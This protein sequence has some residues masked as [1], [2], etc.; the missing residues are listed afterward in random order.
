MNNATDH[1]LIVFVLSFFV[2][3]LSAMIGASFLR[4]QRKLE[5]DVRQDFGVI[6]AATLTLLGLIIGFSFSMAVSRYDQRKNYE[7]AEANAIGT[8]YVRADLLPAADA[9]KV[10]ALLRNY[11]DQRVLF[12]MTRDEQQIQQINARTAQLQTELWSA[13]L[14]PAAAQPTPTVALAVSG[15]NDVL[16]SQGYTQAAWWNRIPIAA[17]VLMAVIAICCNV[18]VGYGARNVKAEGILLL[19]LPFVVSIAFFLIAD[20]DSPHG[21][22][23][24]VNPHNLASLVESLRA[25]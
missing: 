21:G 11:L 19:I 5:E 16:N 12:Y 15:M 13:I 22:V 4:R 14:P 20:I 2:L 18:L 7:E 3:S 6:L 10:R 17:W 23:I 24:H 1:P 25:H 8:E 9:A